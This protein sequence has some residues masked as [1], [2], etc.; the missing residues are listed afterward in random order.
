[1]DD[2]VYGLFGLDPKSRGLDILKE[3]HWHNGILGE[4]IEPFLDNI[5]F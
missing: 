1:M 5:A 4:Q 3:W 2:S